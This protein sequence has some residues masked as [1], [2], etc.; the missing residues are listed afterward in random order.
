MKYNIDGVLVP[1]ELIE[2][3]IYQKYRDLIY[4]IAHFPKNSFNLAIKTTNNFYER[5][6]IKQTI[7][8]QL[9]KLEHLIH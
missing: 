3:N 1:Q 5:V 8:V 4:N 2:R 9:S 7:K 6:R